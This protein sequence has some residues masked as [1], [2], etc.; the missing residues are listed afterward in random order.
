MCMVGLPARGKSYL[1]KKLRRFLRWNGFVSRVATCV[2]VSRLPAPI[3]F[4]HQHAT[5]QTAEE[6]NAGNKRRE[7][8]DG[9]GQSADFF[10]GKSESGLSKRD[11]IALLTF[12]D[13]AKWVHEGYVGWRPR[14]FSS[15]L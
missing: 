4:A 14:I 11:E 6:F 5:R 12:D 13:L 9:G 8:M 3:V 7:L 2:A 15:T 10:S 1:S